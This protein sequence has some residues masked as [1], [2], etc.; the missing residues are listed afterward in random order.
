MRALLT[1]IVKAIASQIGPGHSECVYQKSLSMM[2][3]ESGI[4]H[5][6]EFHVPVT[7]A[8]SSGEKFNVGSER[9]DVLLY[10]AQNR[11]CVIELKAIA[12]S[13]L[14]KNSTAMSAQHIQL[15]KY[16]RL[17]PVENIKLAYVINFRQ[18]ASFDAPEKIEVEVVEYDT[19]T[20]DWTNVDVR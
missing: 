11:A 16:I 13:V 14:L 10:D 19:D 9:I 15:M 8:G 4:R 20:S 12:A 18:A 7:L 6:C 1:T 17:K 5:Q 3:A 2:L